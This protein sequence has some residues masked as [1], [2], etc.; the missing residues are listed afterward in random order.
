MLMQLNLENDGSHDAMAA[1]L[2]AHEFA[3]LMG[4]YHDGE[5]ASTG[6]GN[7]YRYKSK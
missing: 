3:H 5:I 6:K 2:L 7:P 1:K 4:A